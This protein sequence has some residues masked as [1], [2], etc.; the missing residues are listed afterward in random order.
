MDRYPLQPHLRDRAQS[1]LDGSAVGGSAVR[2]R[3]ISFVA[4]AKG[5]V[6]DLARSGDGT[7]SFDFA[8]DEGSVPLPLSEVEGHGGC[9]IQETAAL[10]LAA[11]F[12]VGLSVT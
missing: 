12:G 4:P 9:S 7:R 8:Q 6:K 11:R 10:P 5:L 1:P 2:A 3:F